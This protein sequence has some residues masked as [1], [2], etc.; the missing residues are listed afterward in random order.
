[1][2]NRAKDHCILC[3]FNYKKS[4]LKGLL[5]CERCHFITTDLDL[6]DEELSGLYKG[7]YF[8]GG[9]YA[10]YLS[11]REI[12]QK[13]LKARLEVLLRFVEHTEKKRLLEI[14]CAYGFFLELAREVFGKVS[15]IDISCEAVKYSREVLRLDTMSGDYLNDPMKMDYDVC[16]LWDTVEH[17]KEPHLFIQKISSEM[18]RDGLLAI[19]T[20][21][22]ESLNA[23]FRGKRWRQIRPPIHL[24]YFS[25]RTL[26][27]L[28]ER[29]GFQV[30]Y[31]AH[32]GSYLSLNNIFHIILVARN[33]SPQLYRWL[34]HAGLLRSNI[35]LNMFD[36]LYVIG[37][38]R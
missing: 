20:G 36:L 6:S 35:Y 8:C 19:T 30:V 10:D 15:G 38:K 34:N 14:G 2:D 25:R 12:I 17:L 37:K 7:T 33:G 9:E 32:P 22:I 3:G 27:Q 31:T 11:D 24:H 18:K 4:R 5:E 28:L 26:I 29:N 21:D 13:N 23:R 1:M 16:C